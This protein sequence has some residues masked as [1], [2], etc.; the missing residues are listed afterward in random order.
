MS[1]EQKLG[2]GFEEIVAAEARHAQPEVFA[3]GSMLSYDERLLLHW[4]TRAGNPG[5][6]AV[7]DAG[8]FL[9]GST[10]SLGGGVLA[11]EGGSRAPIHVYDRFEFGADSERVWVPDGFDFAVGGSTMPVF[12]HQVQRVRPLLHV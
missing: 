11:R 7:V 12:E 3:V 10:V 8:C 6:E 2:T 4:A 1:A 9:G 5:P